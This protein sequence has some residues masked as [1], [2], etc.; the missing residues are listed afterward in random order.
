MI[1]VS[2]KLQNPGRNRVTRLGPGFC[3][4]FHVP[5]GAHARAYISDMGVRGAPDFTYSVVVMPVT[6]L[7][8]RAR[9]AAEL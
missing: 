6:L 4:I 3:K 7:N 8:W 9:W 5:E 2:A 1:F